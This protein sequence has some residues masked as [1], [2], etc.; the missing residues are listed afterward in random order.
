M[1][2]SSASL[3]QTI[4]YRN[5]Y[6]G[7]I[8]GLDIANES[9]CIATSHNIYPG[10]SHKGRVEGEITK[11]YRYHLH[12]SAKLLNQQFF[13]FLLS[14]KNMEPWTEEIVW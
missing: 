13:I 3:G 2:V 8:C 7:V 11:H 12:P 14:I 5:I 10:C 1:I 4:I 9:A 6:V